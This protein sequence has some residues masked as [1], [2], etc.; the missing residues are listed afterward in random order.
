MLQLYRHQ[1]IALSYLRLNDSFCLFMEQGTGKTIPTLIRTLELLR[2]GEAKTA[3]IVAPKSALGAWERDVEKFGETEQICFKQRVTLVNYDK[4]WRGGDKSVYNRDFDIIVLDEAHFIKNRTSNRSAFLLKLAT[5]ARYRYALTGTPISNGQLENIWSLIAFMDPYYDRGHIYSNIFARWFQQVADQSGKH[6][7]GMIYRGSY[8][9]FTHRY[10]ILNQYHKPSSYI[11]VREL[12]DLIGR[13]SY[14]VKKSE[15]LD[16]PDKLPDEIVYVDQASK[17]L[18]KRLA[19]ESALEE[20][21]ILADNPLSRLVKLRQLASGFL[22]KHKMT[23]SGD[24][25][26]T[27]TELIEA[28]CNKIEILTELIEGYP[29]D[30]KLVIFCEFKHSIQLIRQLLFKLDIP[31]LT[32]DGDQKDKQ[33]WR[34]F[35]DDPKMR[36]IIC[37]YQT[38][39]AGIDLFAAD[40]IIYYEPTLRSQLLEQSRDRI[41]RTGQTTKCSYIHLITRGTVE[42]D[43]YR[44]L[45]G[46]S[47]FSEKLF[48]EY[49]TSYRRSYTR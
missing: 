10:C 14:R 31:Y 47:D 19:T 13:Y 8:T 18:Y 43:I 22:T 36:V 30:K 38:A 42:V 37:Q 32:L 12:Q 2:T 35:Q 27:E 28:K 23:V 41:H 4:I 21:D 39:S 17:A 40:T 46:Y 49:M 33:I 20:Y 6:K 9:E 5:R 3:L 45:A 1:K 29:D 7:D 44:A 11:N 26:K 25:I 24:K 16:L 34:R 48:V 15:C